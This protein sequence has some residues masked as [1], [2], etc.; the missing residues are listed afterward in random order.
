VTAAR[1]GTWALFALH[2]LFCGG[3]A[4]SAERILFR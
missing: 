1:S 4:K 2:A 3:A